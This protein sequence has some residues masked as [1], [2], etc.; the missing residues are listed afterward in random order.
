MSKILLV[1][2]HPLIVEGYVL[3]LSKSKAELGNIEFE[4]AFDCLTAKETIDAAAAR[5]ESFKLAIVDFSLPTKE[6]GTLEDGG[7]IVAYIQKMMPNC[8]TI[9]LTGHTEVITI[10]NIVKNIRPDGLVSKHEITPDNL[11]EIVKSVMGGDRYQSDIVKHCLSEIVRKEVMYDDY[12]REILV[13]LSKGYKLQELENHIPLSNPAIK[14]RLAKMKNVFEVSDTAN[15][16]QL[17][18]KEGFV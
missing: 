8:K 5:G 10:Y 3:A 2:D 18:L 14:K 11:L 15:L 12:N 7:D 4:K 17:V 16:I 1:D 6:G 13:L 9:I